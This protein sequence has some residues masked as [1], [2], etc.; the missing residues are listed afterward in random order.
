MAGERSTGELDAGATDRARPSFT[1]RPGRHGLIG[2]F[3]G[4]Q[5]AVGG[6]LVVAVAFALAVLTAPL[7]S[8]GTGGPLDPRPTA[9][10]IGPAAE[11][12]RVGDRAPELAVGRPDGSTF[13]LADLD[14][15]PIRL[16]DLRGHPVW[17]N[18]WASWCPP[19]QSET[20]ILRDAYGRFRSQGL[21]IV[22]I[23]VQESS[24]ED[25]AAYVAR[26]G[27]RYRVGFDASGDV[28]RAY[29][30]Y[31]L[32]TQFFLDA[33]GIIRAVVQGPLDSASAAA[34]VDS[35]APGGAEGSS[36]DSPSAVP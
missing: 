10:L 6:L 30:V 20:P 33:R 11:G 5:L 12:L 31:A 25:V 24:V 13:Q 16:A 19:C 18:F 26:Y 35:I 28:F 8:I 9:Y 3:G 2:P 23:S 27:I 36:G 34:Y 15:R 29:R 4:G 14:G 22:G 21:E 32:P 7:G 17:I 1:H